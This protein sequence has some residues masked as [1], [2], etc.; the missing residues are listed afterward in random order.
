MLEIRWIVVIYPVFNAFVIKLFGKILKNLKIDNLDRQ[1]NKQPL[2][3]YKFNN[4]LQNFQT[5]SLPI[6]KIALQEN[7]NFNKHHPKNSI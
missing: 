6:K 1:L 3:I 7:D 2:E 5:K 4:F